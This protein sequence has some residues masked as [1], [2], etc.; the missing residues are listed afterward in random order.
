MS[1]LDAPRN[2][3]WIGC[4]DFGTA[5]SK[6]AL[7][8]RKPTSRLGAGDIVPLA[9]GSRDVIAAQSQYLLPS[10]VY[11]TDDRLFFGAEAQTAALRGE[12]TGRQAFSSPKQY[13]STHELEVLDEALGSGIDPTGSYTP[14]GLLVLFLA[15]LLLQTQEAAK[16]AKVPWPVPLRVARPAWD[17]AR[18]EAG[19]A[20]LKSLILSA[21]DVAGHLI[22]S[23]SKPGGLAHS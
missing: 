2:R 15:Y 7:I 1:L 12:R 8:K 21:F 9:V 19:E 13:L 23:L 17:R 18:A 10:L 16:L 20:T 6:V 4:I 11:V 5:L 3:S 14:R 22:E